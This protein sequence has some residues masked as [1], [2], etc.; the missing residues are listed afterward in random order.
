MDFQKSDIS[1]R[2]F[3]NA[4]AVGAAV[5]ATGPVF[6]VSA[7]EQ[8]KKAVPAIY[9]CGVCGHVE[10]GSAPEFCPVCHAPKDKFAENNA[11]FGDAMK[12]YPEVSGS[13][14]PVITIKKDTGLIPEM[15]GK[16]V[17]VRVGK[18][19]HPME[20]QHHIK[21]IDFYIDDKFI[22]R[23]FLSLK[24]Y[25]AASWY[26]NAAGSKIRMIEYCTVHGYWQAETAMA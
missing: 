5:M 23:V 22:N 21:F 9:V 3:L 25:P 12:K 15:P 10:F 26:T 16:E 8:P 19:L 1:R 7:G 14:D 20:E 13:H 2:E 18:K 6:K 4:A 24:L 17:S 11:L